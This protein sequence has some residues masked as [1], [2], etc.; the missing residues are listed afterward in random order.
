MK[1]KTGGRASDL[2][3]QER[4]SARGAGG[5]RGDKRAEKRGDQRGDNRS[6]Q[7]AGGRG[8]PAGGSRAA[9]SPIQALKAAVKKSAGGA[10]RKSSKKP[11]R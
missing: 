6:G 10:G 3:E 7:G 11:R 8:S 2:P 1:D 9:V 5:P 4:G